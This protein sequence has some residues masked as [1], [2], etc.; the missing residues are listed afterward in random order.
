MISSQGVSHF[1]SPASLL[2]HGHNNYEDQNGGDAWTQQHK[3]FFI[4]TDSNSDQQGPSWGPVL[5]LCSRLINLSWECP[6]LMEEQQFIIIGI[7]LWIWICFLCLH[8]SKAPHDS[9]HSFW[10]MNSL[11]CNPIGY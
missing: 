1:P 2:V 11:H 5:L 8:A 3:I 10:S 7:I 6:F 9:I 4:K